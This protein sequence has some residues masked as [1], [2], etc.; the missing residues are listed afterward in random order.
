MKLHAAFLPLIVLLTAPA[1]LAEDAAGKWTGALHRGEWPVP[2]TVSIAKNADGSLV[3]SAE[4]PSGSVTLDKI[5]SDGSQLTFDLP[6]M[7]R[8]KLTWDEAAKVW[9]GVMTQNGLDFP[10]ELWRAG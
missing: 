4:A 3:G 5:A 9:K 2:L 8:C 6:G 7:T 10:L 1:A